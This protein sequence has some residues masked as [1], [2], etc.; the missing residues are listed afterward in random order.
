MDVSI[1]MSSY[2]RHPLNLL[3]LNALENQT[4]DL[5]KMEVILIDDSSTDETPLLI[6]YSPPYQFKYI[7]NK[8]NLGLAASRNKG[9]KLAKGEV[10]IFLDAEMLVDNKYVENNYKEH[11]INKKAVVIGGTKRGKIYSY[12][13]PELKSRQIK[14]ICSLLKSKKNRKWS[15]NRLGKKITSRNLPKFIKRLTSPVKLLSKEDIKEFSQIKNLTK[16]KKHT[17]NVLKQ[18][19]GNFETSRLN[20]LACVGNLSIKKEVIKK[21][22][23][24]DEDFK[25]WGTEDHEL[26]FRLKK[27]GVKFIVNPDLVRYHQEHPREKGLLK[28]GKRNRV[29]FQQKHPVLDVCIRSIKS[30]QKVDYNFMESILDEHYLI[31]RKFPGKYE[32]FSKCIID[33]LQQVALLD[34]QQKKISNLIGRV[35]GEDLKKKEQ[36]FTWRDELNSYMRYPNI[37]KLF[38]LLVR[39]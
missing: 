7:P 30:I 35:V 28:Q 3:S 11:L 15:S 24:Y 38:D 13:F 34:A 26:A 2:N 21:V 19:G 22:G 14:D 9:L 17:N 39:Q 10:I 29:L 25:E 32:D 23:G 12:L 36:I 6:N 16:E 1:V 37:I 8:T 33:L 31:K 18:L 27:E 4:F 20:W 5:T